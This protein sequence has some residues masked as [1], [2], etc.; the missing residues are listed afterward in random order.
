M[1][2]VF[3]PSSKSADARD[4]IEHDVLEHRAEALARGV[5][6]GLGFLRELDALGVA[7]ALEVEDAVGAPAVLVIADQRAVR[8][9]RQRGLAGARQAE[10]DRGIAIGADIGRAVHRHHALVGQIVVQR[11]EHA[12]LHLAGIIR[13][14]DQD[15][16]A[17]E[18][19]R[20]NGL[21]THAMAFGIGFERRQGNDGQ[22]RHEGSQFLQLRPDQQRADEQR[23][24][25]EL[26]EDASLDAE[27]R[28]GATIKV[29]RV[30]RLAFGVL[31][32]IVAQQL[33]LVRRDRLVATPP[34]VL[35]ARGIADGELV[36]RRAAG[37]SAGLRAQRAF[38]GDDGL[39]VAKRE[40][41]KR[42][43]AVIPVNLT[44]IFETE[45]IG[46]KGTVVHAR[47]FH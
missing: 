9:G 34:H 24:P 5:D 25:G 20:D 4:R 16:L 21:R 40:F 36:L 29:L 45:S 17:G 8:I 2:S 39:A 26:G 1:F 23:V 6:R 22:L 18:I 3:E 35:F 10:E 41:V 43:R 27:F 30:K 37:V 13:P 46:A 31:D 12:L 11:G 15:D 42:G 32:E 38:R 7:A 33:E 47:L 19:D 44:E 28:I 14:A